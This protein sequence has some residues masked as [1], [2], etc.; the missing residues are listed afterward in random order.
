MTETEIEAEL[1]QLRAELSQQQA[2]H[3]R[4]KKNWH[5]LGVVSG[6]LGILFAVTGLGVL[7]VDFFLDFAKSSATTH[8]Y[9]TILGQ[10]FILTSLPMSVLAQAL[11]GDRT[12]TH[13]R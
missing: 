1:K 12:Q 4:Q 8:Q 2:R 10:Q 5:L 9:I 11:R 7:V 3:E 6:I 13:A